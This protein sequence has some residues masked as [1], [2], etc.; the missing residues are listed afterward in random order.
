MHSGSR[1]TEANVRRVIRPSFYGIVLCGVIALLGGVHEKKMESRGRIFAALAGV[2]GLIYS[3]LLLGDPFVRK[4][5]AI[6]Q[7]TGNYSID[8]DLSQARLSLMGYE[9]LS[10][11]I[12]LS[13]NGDFSG[14]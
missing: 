14:T 3:L 9:N 6:H 2:V 8:M 4:P 1:F 12:A 11:R 10:G 5:I 13:V 7:V